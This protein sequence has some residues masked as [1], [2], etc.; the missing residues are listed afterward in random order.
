MAAFDYFWELSGGDGSR[1]VAITDPG[2]SL[3]K[4]AKKR[5]FR[6]VFQADPNV[7]GRYSALTVFGLVPAALLGLDVKRLLARAAWMMEQ[8]ERDV[9]AARNPGLVLGAVMAEAAL[10][11]P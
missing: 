5:K 4:L 7:G 1:F 8:S 3:E 6:A 10:G 2:T 9:L 11:R